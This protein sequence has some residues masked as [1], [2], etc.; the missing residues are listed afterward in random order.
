MGAIKKK[1]DNLGRIVLP[2]EYRT[3]LGIDNNSMVLVNLENDCITVTSCKETCVLCGK[4]LFGSRH[5]KLCESCIS[6]IKSI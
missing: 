2:I 5:S 6:E 1:I 3:H 4:E